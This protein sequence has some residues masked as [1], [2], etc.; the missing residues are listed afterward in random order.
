MSEL[1]IRGQDLANA[2]LIYPGLLVAVDDKGNLHGNV[3]NVLQYGEV[4]AQEA[5]V[6]TSAR[7][8]V[9]QIVEYDTFK[10]PATDVID[11][12]GN[13]YLWRF[14]QVPAEPAEIWRCSP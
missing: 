13:L 2:G 10:R 11:G 5:L 1:L 12:E 4:V 7:G 6:E 14:D 9:L 3:V 8:Q